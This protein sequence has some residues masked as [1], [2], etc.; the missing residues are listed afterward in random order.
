MSFK[1]TQL[2]DAISLT[3]YQDKP[4]VAYYIGS[5]EVT[6]RNGEQQMHDF[7]KEDGTKITVWGFVALDRL[8]EQTPRGILTKVTYTGKSKEKNKYGNHSHTCTVFF[9][10]DKKLDGFEQPAPQIE[11]DDDLP[12]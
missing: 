10:T 7:Q 11:N 2:A 12:F 1:E 9:D 3:E 4:M 8:L 6:T 5:K